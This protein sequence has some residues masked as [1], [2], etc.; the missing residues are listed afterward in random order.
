M[1]DKELVRL[2]VTYREGELTPDRVR[3]VLDAIN[4]ELADPASE[5]SREAEHIGAQVGDIELKPEPSG[6]VAEAFII[7]LAVS[8]A[9]GVATQA[10]KLFFDKVIKPRFDRV[11]DDAVKG[12]ETLP[13]EAKK[14]GD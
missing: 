8:F 3:E 1:A 6:F 5:A 14:V 10:G 13:G 7:G 12:V 4:V 11:S 2:R 9:G